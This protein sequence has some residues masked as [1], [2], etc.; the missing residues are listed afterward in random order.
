MVH[1]DTGAVADTFSS[2]L[3][4][5]NYVLVDCVEGA[6]RQ[7]QGYIKDEEN[8]ILVFIGN[9]GFSSLGKDTADDNKGKENK[10]ECNETTDTG[11]LS[12]TDY[13]E[14]ICI[15]DGMSVDFVTDENSE[16]T[17][18]FI[19]G[20]VASTPFEGN[21]IVKRGTRYIIRDMFYN[22]KYTV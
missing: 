16:I 14:G 18:H 22:S 10:E 20:G 17:R 12:G 2:P 3:T 9:N 1:K 13:K 7:T 21:L 11:K 4:S 19:K 5:T 15:G 8:K 6:C